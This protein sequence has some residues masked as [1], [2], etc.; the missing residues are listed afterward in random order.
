M[1][2]TRLAQGVS[3][4]VVGRA[5]ASDTRA[6]QA[7]IALAF[8]HCCAAGQLTQ[9]PAGRAA[10][11]G[12]HA[13][14]MD[15]SRGIPPAKS[16][17]RQL[18]ARI[19]FVL[20]GGVGVLL[21][22]ACANVG[23]LLLARA[24]ARTHELSVRLALGASQ[25]R[26]IR[27]LL[28]ESSQI[29]GAGA[30]V[31]LLIALWGTSLLSRHLPA[32]LRLLEPVIAIRP[33]PVLFAFTALAAIACTTIFG[34]L[35]AIRAT[36]VDPSVGLRQG[37]RR[38]GGR[39]GMLDRGIVAVQVALALVLVTSATLLVQT[40][41]NLRHVDAGFETA[42]LLLADV[43]VRGTRYAQTGMRPLYGDMLRQ[44][45]ALPGVQAAGMATR[46]PLVYGAG[47]L[48]ELYVPGYEAGPGDEVGADYI[49]ATP[50][51]LAG[52]GIALRAGRDF[53][54]G[55]DASAPHVA[56]VS[57]R[58]AQKYFAGRNPVGATIRR[59]DAAGQPLLVIGVAADAKFY[60]MRGLA[61]PTIYVP[62][63]QSR[64]W[65]FL[66]LAAHTSIAPAALVQALRSALAASAPGVTVRWVQRMDDAI[67]RQL[68]REQT[69]AWLA[70]AF[71]ALA[72]LLAAAGLYGVVAY[73][74]TARAAEI[75][76]RMALGADTMQVVW[77]VMRQ[78][79]TVVGV[80]GVIGVPLALGGA[81][82]IAAP[83][84]GVTPWHPATLG[85]V[86]L[87]L[88]GV[89]ALASLLPARRA[90]RVDPLIAIRAE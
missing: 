5:I 10:P 48:E 34:V 21:L 53:S 67:D 64:D 31:G 15:V 36:R 20:M 69:L 56:I 27:Q 73:H 38:S 37:A 2:A 39:I 60:D 23:N 4:I 63:E 16:D 19:L 83:L 58:I 80:G 84:Y 61:L 77:M 66:A 7:A 50:G 90:A 8:E 18:Y 78:S 11:R 35:P 72:L 49:S 40:L 59:G 82:A 54:T 13:V 17:L 79:L 3:L 28:I 51:F 75:G 12:E 88:L 89:G 76:V 65:G 42:H 30:G 32:N 62:F 24:T 70:A 45:R 6:A 43:E 55:D 46:V 14:L 85:G 33:N 57:E 41:R 25:G 68:A 26:L 22:I 74:V 44:V 9:L 71:G 87:A 29:A 47:P 52:V 86:V 1:P 81:R